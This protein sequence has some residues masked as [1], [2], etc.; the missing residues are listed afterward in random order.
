MKSMVK[1]G[2]VAVISA[3]LVV[4]AMADYAKPQ[5]LSLRAGF[6]FAQGD[7]KAYEGQNW[8]TIGLE[9]KMKDIDTGNSASTAHYSLSLDYYGKGGFSNVPLLY[10][11]VGRNP[12]FYY[13]VGAGVGFG[14][15]QSGS[16]DS[17][18]DFNYQLSIGKDLNFGSQPFFVEARYFGSGR[19]SLSGFS[20]VGG[21]RF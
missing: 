2:L 17:T 8:F 14:R 10:N 21:I 20:V 4:P 5:G 11:Y 9:K 3:A 18:V 16:S 6:F 15:T 12:D 13:S 19:T 7:G 1:I